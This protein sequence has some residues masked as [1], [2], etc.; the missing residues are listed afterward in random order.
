MDKV[1][2]RWDG[3]VVLQD[4]VLEVHSSEMPWE[5][6]NVILAMDG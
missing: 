2:S 6:L 5:L 1:S 3:E 4:L